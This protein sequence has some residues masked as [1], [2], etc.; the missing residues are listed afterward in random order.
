MMRRPRVPST[1]AHNGDHSRGCGRPV[2]T[3]LLMKID[4]ATSPVTSTPPA[5]IPLPSSAARY[6][7]TKAIGR[8]PT[9][10]PLG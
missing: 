8:Q 10:S 7:R 1:L 6:A 2:R 3:P 4:T 5:P 9:G